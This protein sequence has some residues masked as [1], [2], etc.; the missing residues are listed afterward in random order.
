MAA[1]RQQYGSKSAQNV[2][3]SCGPKTGI[4]AAAA[5]NGNEPN[6]LS[7]VTLSDKRRK[8]AGKSKADGE[9]FEPPVDFRP[10]RFSR[11]PP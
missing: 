2:A 8:A 5:E 11:P 9:G 10:Q 7:Y 1:N 6:T 3:G 4:S